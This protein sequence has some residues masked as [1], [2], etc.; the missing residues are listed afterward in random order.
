VSDQVLTYYA[1]LSKIYIQKGVDHNLD[2]SYTS[3][4][5]W[6]L[7]TQ[8]E[9]SLDCHFSELLVFWISSDAGDSLT[10]KIRKSLRISLQPS[11]NEFETLESFF[12][13]LR[14]LVLSLQDETDEHAQFEV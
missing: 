13:D 14:V 1:L 5:G 3:T 2:S 10:E 9:D 4:H 7:L 11:L 8:I 6:F 12:Y